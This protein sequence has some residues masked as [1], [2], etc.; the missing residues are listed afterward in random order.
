MDSKKVIG[1][2]IAFLMIASIFGATLDYFT[3]GAGNTLEYN[4]YEFRTVNGQYVTVIDDEP[5]VFNI[6]PTDIEHITLDEQTRTLLASP[7]LTITYNPNTTL[8]PSFAEAQYYLEYITT[9]KITVERA[10]TN[11]TGTELPQ[12]TCADATPAQPVILFQE[13]NETGIT[14]QNNC[15]TINALDNYDTAQYSERL[16]YH[17]FK[18][19]P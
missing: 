19:I 1:A 5:R 6:Y 15:L 12:K 2:F 4:D 17:F 16:A 13:S 11:N 9:D 14:T 7:V 18:I 8:A 3:T 10:L